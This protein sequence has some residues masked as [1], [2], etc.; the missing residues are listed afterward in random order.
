MTGVEVARHLSAAAV[1]FTL[2]DDE[3]AQMVQKAG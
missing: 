1:T 3:M 2:D